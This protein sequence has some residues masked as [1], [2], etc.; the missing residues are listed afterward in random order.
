MYNGDVT[1]D[2]VTKLLDAISQSEDPRQ[3]LLANTFV[4][5]QDNCFHAYRFEFASAPDQ[6]MADERYED[7]VTYI[8]RQTRR[9]GLKID[10]ANTLNPDLSVSV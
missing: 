2:E 8:Q 5:I 10:V 6:A 7:L 9:Y 1:K 3:A 4:E